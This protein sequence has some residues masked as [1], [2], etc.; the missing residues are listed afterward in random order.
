MGVELK[1]VGDVLGQQQVFFLDRGNFAQ[2]GSPLNPDAN[3]KYR[4]NCDQGKSRRERIA[5][6]N[7]PKYLLPNA[8]PICGTCHNQTYMFTVS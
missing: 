2:I 3:E 1:R 8:P 4:D 5:Q 7:P 6:P